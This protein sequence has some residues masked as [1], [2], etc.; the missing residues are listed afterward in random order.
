MPRWDWSQ[1]LTPAV[2]IVLVGI[3]MIFAHSGLSGDH[4]LGALRQA[5]SLENELTAELALL[6]TE[7]ETLENRVKRLDERYLDL[8]LLDE[9]ARAVLGRTRPDE[10]VIR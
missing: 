10:I 5:E 8:D 1:I 9:R 4:G 7:R 3:L 6:R 2:Y